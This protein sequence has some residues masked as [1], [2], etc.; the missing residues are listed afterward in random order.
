MVVLTSFFIILQKLKVPRPKASTRRSQGNVPAI[1][2]VYTP[3]DHT[4]LQGP[5]PSSQITLSEATSLLEC[6]GAPNGP[7]LSHG[8]PVA[9]PPRSTC[10]L[11]DHTYALTES[12][13][14]F[15]AISGVCIPSDQTALEDPSLSSQITLCNSASLAEQSGAPNGPRLSHGLPLS[16]LP[17]STFTQSDHIYAISESPREL[18]RKLIYLIDKIES[19][20]KKCKTKRTCYKTEE[21]S[22]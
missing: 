12:P 21:E 22:R 4:A 17:L 9:T 11:P 18:K 20:V 19:K 2:G 13:R 16:R 3:S 15:K 8:L 1:N 6:S 10:T 14:E 5:S 7:R